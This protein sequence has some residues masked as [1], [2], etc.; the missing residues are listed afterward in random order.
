MV[1]GDFTIANYTEIAGGWVSKDIPTPE[2]GEG[3][4]TL[5]SRWL[6]SL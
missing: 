1:F 3:R 2:R 5:T 4:T 6:R